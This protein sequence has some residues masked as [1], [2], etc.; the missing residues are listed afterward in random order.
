MINL[1]DLSQHSFIYPVPY[2]MPRTI[3][4]LH[5]EYH[6]PVGIRKA[7]DSSTVA[8]SYKLGF[9]WFYLNLLISKVRYRLVDNY[10]CRMDLPFLGIGVISANFEGFRKAPFSRESLIYLHNICGK[11]LLSFKIFNR[12]S[13]P[14][15]F[16]PPNIEVT[17]S[18]VSCS[19]FA[20]AIFRGQFF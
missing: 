4:K 11:F 3:G 5:A 20:G 12:M 9:I 14:D 7:M 1:L 8:C 10:L 6:E 15:D 2:A 17:S 18:T 13:P 19:S 16:V